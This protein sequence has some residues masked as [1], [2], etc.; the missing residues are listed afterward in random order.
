MGNPGEDYAATRH[1]VGTW[2]V[3]ELVRRHG[4]RLRR[5]RRE[6]ALTD[7]LRIGDRRL[8]VVV[9]VTFYNEAG[10]AVA[11]LVRRFGITDLDRLV[12]VHDELD[13]P[14]G[15]MKLKFG[16]GLAGN[17]GLKSVRNHVRSADFVRLRIGIDKP[18]SEEKRGRDHV[19][20][21]PS[22]AERPLLEET[23][24]RAADALEFL[25]DH[26]LDTAMN[27]YNTV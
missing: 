23:V 9:P 26:D 5:A 11:P 25:V 12:V 16:G 27:H 19:L 8:A 14:V 6:Q 22:R 21:R 17:N 15:R 20:S 24:S 4:G 2:V 18:V 10:R 13:L 3:D 7:E 1:N